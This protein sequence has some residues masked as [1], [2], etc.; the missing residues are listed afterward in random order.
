MDADTDDDFIKWSFGK[1]PVIPERSF[2]GVSGPLHG[3]NSDR[4]NPFDFFCLFIPI[5]FHTRFANY[6]NKKDKLESTRKHAHVQDCE[7]SSAA[8]IR[9]WFASVMWHGLNQ[10]CTMQHFLNC[11]IDPNR[12]TIL[13]PSCR[14]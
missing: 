12:T 6:T 9:A 7:P 10:G 8:K 11:K 2:T 1:D 13:F 3:F 5:Y 14:Q 4:A